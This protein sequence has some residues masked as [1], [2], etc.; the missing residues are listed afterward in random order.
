MK[1]SSC[2]TGI[3][4]LGIPTNDIEKTIAFYESIG[5]EI[6]F[7][8]VNE[9]SG[10][11]VAFLSLKN[12]II[13]TYQNNCAVGKPGAIDHVALDVSDIETA[14][15]I[16]KK[17]NY[18]MLDNEIRFLRFWENGVRFFNILGPNDEKVEFSQKL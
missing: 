18:T 13:E 11:R 9:A 15:D 17:G 16:I 7:Q 8:T 12:L 6:A 4:H 2:V 3:Q 14:F 5:F 10:D 1:V